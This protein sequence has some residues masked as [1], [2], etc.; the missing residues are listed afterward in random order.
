MTKGKAVKDA[1]ILIVKIWNL[2]DFFNENLKSNFLA[3]FY[4]VSTALST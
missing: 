3:N 4:E 1:K 2:K